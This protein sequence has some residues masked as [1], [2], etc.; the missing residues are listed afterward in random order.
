[1]TIKIG[2]II[3]PKNQTLKKYKYNWYIV[4]GIYENL[5]KTVF[6]DLICLE[7]FEIYKKQYLSKDWIN[8]K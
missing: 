3:C 1:M 8:L 2:D 6:Y 4:F 7:N 5:Q